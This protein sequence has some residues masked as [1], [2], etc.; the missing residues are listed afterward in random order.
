LWRA[1]EQLEPRRLLDGGF[2]PSVDYGTGDRPL[3]LTSADFN[4]DGMADLAVANLSS[5]TVSVLLNTG[6]GIFAAKVDY[7]AGAGPSAVTSADFNGDGKA[8]LAVARQWSNAV[9]VLLNRGNG[10]FD[11]KADYAVGGPPES[12]TSADFNG[13]GKA[14]LATANPSS[15]TVSVLMNQGDGTFATNTDYATGDYPSFVASADFNGDGKADLVVTNAH[16]DTVSVLLSRGDGTFAPKVDYPAGFNPVSLTSGDFNGDG[17][18]DLAVISASSNMVRILLN[19]G[20]GAFAANVDYA[21]G[22][23]PYHGTSGD[24]NGDGKTDLAIANYAGSG[25]VSVL[26]NQGSVTFGSRVGYAT[27]SY[28]VAVT[29]ADFNGDGKADL[30][31]ANSDDNTVSVLLQPPTVTINQA[32]TQADPTNTSPINFT[33]VFSETMTGFTSD[34]IVLSGTAGATTATVTGSGATYNVAVSGMTQPGTV[35][36]NVP[37]AV[38]MDAAGNGN[39]A[40][41]STDNTVVFDNVRPTVTIN[42]AAAQTD[43]TNSPTVDFTVV[44]SEP[45]TGFTAGDVTLGG[46]AGATTAIVTGSGTTYNVAVSG[47]TQSGAVGASVPAEAA[48][49]AA[50]NGNL[51]STSTDNSAAYDNIVPT[52]TINQASAQADPTNSSAINFTVVFSEEVLGFTTGDVVLGGTAGATT[53]EV[54]GSG[55]TYNVAV[56]GMTQPG[57]VTVN[58]PSAVAMD[59]AGNG[60]AA[61]TSTDNTV[62]F[63]NAVPTVAIEQAVGQADPTNG[64]TVNFTVVFTEPVTGF[65]T[66]DVTLGGTAG[67]TTAIVT[68]SGTTY[69]VAVSGM[70]RSGTV[71]ASVAAG[72]ASDDLGDP[73]AASTSTDNTVT[74]DHVAPQAWLTAAT[75]AAAPK[76]PPY[77]FKV[78]YKDD[79]ALKASTVGA[80][81]IV[82]YPPKSVKKYKPVATWL[83][84]KKPFGNTKSIVTYYS[85]PAPGGTWDKADNGLYTVVL[86]Y[87]HI[88]DLTGNAIAPKKAGLTLGT[89][90]VQ[91]GAK[92][93]KVAQAHASA[94]PLSAATARPVQKQDRDSLLATLFC[95]QPV[96]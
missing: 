45:V 4:G 84:S 2:C 82:V 31:V 93:A 36:V 96:L 26:L 23:T 81:D 94:S 20:D 56:S 47:M 17:K 3:S 13:D 65:T 24:F 28:S 49:D 43:P 50:G 46:T 7:A 62:T 42:Q 90:K 70:T 71:I 15:N 80:G 19:Q 64:A 75:V 63:D 38:A 51:D 77:W 89:F 10:V 87:K 41:T 68:G 44:F 83:P 34:D 8:D 76:K 48:T 22:D 78:T 35:T 21:A 67:A 39:A 66:G 92:S 69:N 88:T 57:T 27:G 55:T 16:G 25:M 11:V 95:S 53:A 85:I 9:S 33:V 29:S 86:V 54:T 12:L 58:V 91:I 5:D 73:N 30:A 60:N 72:V 14:D 61:S 59:A 40:S 37:S 32:S 6:N 18:P 52:V 74:V 79:I 1:I